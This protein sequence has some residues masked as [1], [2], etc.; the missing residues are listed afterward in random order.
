MRIR[1]ALRTTALSLFSEFFHERSW[2]KRGAKKIALSFAVLMVAGAVSAEVKVDLYQAGVESS[3]VATN[4]VY[5]YI[6]NDLSV[7]TNANVLSVAA[8]I[9][10]GSNNNWQSN[11]YYGGVLADGF[12]NRGASRMGTWYW[13]NP[14]TESNQTLI[15][16]NTANTTAFT[17]SMVALSGVNEGI[18]ISQSAPT[19]LNLYNDINITTNN[20]FVVAFATIND[21]RDLFAPEKMEKLGQV[22]TDGGNCVAVGTQW[23]AE[24]GVTERITWT[25]TANAGWRPDI[26]VSILAFPTD[27]SGE[28]P[29]YLPELE[30]AN[31]NP[32][33]AGVANNV[34]LS[35]DVILT[36]TEF[37]SAELYLDGLTNLISSTDTSMG[38]TTTVSSVDAYQ[39][40]PLTEHSFSLV[41]ETTKL[42]ET[43]TW[44]FT[45]GDQYKI[46]LSPGK[47]V[48]I[49][50]YSPVV[51]ATIVDVADEASLVTFLINDALV[52]SALSDSS[53]TTIVSSAVG[54]LVA[55]EQVNCQVIINS[56]YYGTVTNDWTFTMG[57]GVGATV[58]N[59][60]PELGQYDIAQTNIPGSAENNIGYSATETDRH[61]WTYISS[62]DRPAQGQTFTTPQ[63][64][65]GFEVTSVWIKNTSYD[66]GGSQ[67]GVGTV[68]KL[69]ITDPA[70]SNTLNFVR[71]AQDVT[72]L[73][74][75]VNN[76]GQWIQLRLADPVVLR[77]NTTYGFD[78]TAANSWFNTA[79]VATDDYAGGTAYSSGDNGAGNNSVNL[80]PSGD[81]SFVVQMNESDEVFVVNSVSPLGGGIL[82]SGLKLEVEM[83]ELGGMLDTELTT[84]LL[85]GEPTYTAFIGAG[86]EYT[87]QADLLALDP[88]T[89]HTGEYIIVSSS[90]E[91]AVTNS[92]IFTMEQGFFIAGQTPRNK[93]TQ[94]N[95][96]VSLSV[97]VVEAADSINS[98]DLVLDG[99]ALGA[100]TFTETGTT[101]V[102]AV[103]G[104]LSPGMHTVD[105]VVQGNVA[106]EPVTNSW[107]FYVRLPTTDRSWN[108]NIAGPSGGAARNVA[109]GTVAISAPSGLNLWNNLVGTGGT[110]AN[111][112]NFN[113]VVDTSGE[114]PI[115]FYTHG[116]YYWGDDYTGGT[117]MVL[118]MF[119]GWWGGSNA[120]QPPNHDAYFT[121]TGLNA[122][123]AY[124]LY[125]Y[126]T[127][128]WNDNDSKFEITD[129]FPADGFKI[130]TALATRNIVA[131]GANDDYSTC[132]E[133]QNYIVFES[134]TPSKD[135]NITIHSG[136]GVDCILSGLQIREHAGEGTLPF[137]NVASVSPTGVFST[138]VV[139][140]EAVIH[141]YVG[142]VD[143][144]NVVL[145]LDGVEVVPD[146]IDK[147]V[148]TTTVSYVTSPLAGGNHTAS[149]IPTEGETNS[150]TFGIVGKRSVPIELAHHWNF[151]DGSGTTVKDI[152]G[153]SDG[154]IIGSNYAWVPGGGL[155][156]FGGGSS[157]DWN[158]G[159]TAGTAGAY[160]D[161]PNGTFS[162]MGEA[163]TI[164]ITYIAESDTI[165]QRV[166]DFGES[167]SRVEGESNWGAG[168]YF[169]ICPGA[170]NN[171]TRMAYSPWF[172]KEEIF[173]IDGNLQ[174]LSNLTHLVWV[175]DSAGHT[176]KMF[177]NG[178]LMHDLEVLE[179]APVSGVNDINCFIGRSQYRDPMF[180]GKVLDLRMYTGLMTDE[181]AQ[182]R[183][184]EVSGTEPPPAEGPAVSLTAPAG[185]PLA[186][187][188]LA[189]AGNGYTVVTNADLTNPDGWGVVGAAPVLDGDYYTISVEF[190]EESSLFYKLEST[191]AQ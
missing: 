87:L 71:S 80:A 62:G 74:S 3:I 12:I 105:V 99:V 162:S 128:T 92:W 157:Y 18:G 149:I 15:V 152:E 86:P 101:T 183:Y 148:S 141:D 113:N 14:N 133:G 77:A 16:K 36:S 155:D 180:D 115:G 38:N 129:G 116:I 167:E 184:Y 179:M 123:A 33:G 160:V 168:S 132:V 57:G 178:V 24:G 142:L 13:Y 176:T 188:W 9:D 153:G 156:L 65:G 185:G 107:D 85:D 53:G 190:G 106:D 82:N 139:T 161:L 118:D 143:T 55:D 69:R 104:V 72:V 111:T 137:A 17:Y 112:N 8:Y 103:S 146:S 67:L 154:T 175:Y 182:D 56:T 181:E 120:G 60:L 79:G 21:S 41:I 138:N 52:T 114:N 140:L 49:N 98:A 44:S 186:I 7:G 110:T 22:Q 1:K 97:Q 134:V 35:V 88:S 191:S 177:E 46:T 108:I 81:R 173:S 172:P 32:T 145:L 90:P 29:Y 159:N 47:D 158:A 39:F 50:E 66:D 100:D 48:V 75:F 94:T 28:A 147:L 96:I 102:S 163:L 109:D 6:V 164:E 43:N 63:R 76:T 117:D 174:S 169:F 135:G 136:F 89:T 121:I 31:V 68:V 83:V 61:E 93:S 23:F 11:A 2:K 26:G 34:E 59:S 10:T 70:R 25:E 45:M 171:K 30:Y 166:L 126:S 122:T 54:P 189:T 58:W 40:D 19:T 125:V 4:G 131:S 165:W 78:V 42:V 20:M 124:D 170:N 73:N 127:W 187:S 27:I 91:Y 119:K 64:E 130:K 37:I 144:N 5:D 95:E 51:S 151:M 84:L 150:W